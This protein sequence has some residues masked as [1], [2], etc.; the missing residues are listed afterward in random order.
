MLARLL[1][2]PLLLFSVSLP[3]SIA[4]A[5]LPDAHPAGF[6]DELTV[7]AEVTP[8]TCFDG[9]DGV[10]KITATGGLAPYHGDVDENGE[11]LIDKLVAG[12]YTYEI[13]DA[14]DV[15]VTVTAIVTQPAPLGVAATSLTGQTAPDT[16]GTVRVVPSGGTSPYVYAWSNGADADTLS[17]LPPGDY[18]VTLTDA[19]GCTVQDSYAVKDLIPAPTGSYVLLNE[20]TCAGDSNATIHLL[21][22]GGVGPYHGDINAK[23]DTILQHM[24]GGDHFFNVYDSRDSL[25]VVNAFVYEPDSMQLEVLILNGERSDKKGRI[26]VAASGGVKP[27]TYDWGNI[28]LAGDLIGNLT[29]GTYHLLLTDENGCTLRDSFVVED[30]TPTHFLAAGAVEIYP[31][32]V[33][34][35]LQVDLRAQGRIRSLTVLSAA[36]QLISRRPYANAESVTLDAAQLPR[37]PGT[38]VLWIETADGRAHAQRF[39]STGRR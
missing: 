12:S 13:Y 39:V 7:N 18:S 4:P 21:A 31:T 25:V 11:L 27:Y 17:S 9:S 14:E 19:N 1:S 15:L 6:S 22:E 16:L 35:F 24:A 3:A 34:D 5:A 8:V 23:G 37:T 38:Y 33:S 36:G 32:L 26:K 20:V 10:V 28:S 30:L 29:N 2:L